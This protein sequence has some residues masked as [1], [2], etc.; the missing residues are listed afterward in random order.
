MEAAGRLSYDDAHARHHTF[1][2]HDWVWFYR[3]SHLE[4]GV[5]SKL[6]YSWT[7]PF[8]IKVLR[9]ASRS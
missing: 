3:K 9:Q 5:T 7:G 1:N 6:K 8:R 4:K 2:F